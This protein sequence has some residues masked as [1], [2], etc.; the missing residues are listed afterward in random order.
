MYIYV[1]ILTEIIQQEMA[2]SAKEKAENL[3]RSAAR[4]ALAEITEAKAASW[5]S[6]AI[7][8]FIKFRN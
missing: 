1:K 8:S 4:N 6:H 3:R 5:P 2:A 7:N